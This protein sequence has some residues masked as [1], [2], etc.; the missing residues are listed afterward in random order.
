M[1]GGTLAR[2]M[3][4]FSRKQILHNEVLHL[5]PMLREMQAML[6]PLLGRSIELVCRLDPGLAP[7][8][9]DLSKLEQV[10]LNLVVNARDAI[11]KT[12]TIT[13]QTRN[14]DSSDPALPP[15]AAPPGSRFILIS[16]SDTGS[17][18]SP[19]TKAHLFEPYFTTKPPGKG[20]GLGLATVDGI[21]KQIG[22]FITVDSELGRGSTFSV[23][24]PAAKERSLISAQSVPEATQQQANAQ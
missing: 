4:D 23:Y 8:V 6:H 17:G 7:V 9:A 21:V 12:G 15:G 3:L 5:N 14:T 1:R 2:Q 11:A 13:I 22:G 18:M 16:V 10:I 24:L 19:E 20:T